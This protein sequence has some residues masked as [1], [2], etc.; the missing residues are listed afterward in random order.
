MARWNAWGNNY[1]GAGWNDWGTG[2]GYWEGSV[3][4]PF[5]YGDVL[6]FALWPYAFYDPFFAYGADFLLTSIFWPG[7]LF[8]PYYAYSPYAYNPY[9][10]GESSLFDIYGN[11][12][13]ANGY[14]DYGGYEGRHHQP[15]H[16]HY[17]RRLYTA[18]SMAN[19]NLAAESS[20]CL[21]CG[22]LAPGVVSLPVEQIKR[23]I[24]PTDAQVAMLNDLKAASAEADNILRASC[25]AEV[26]LTPLARLDAVA[27]R[28]EAMI[29]AVRVLRPPLTTLYNSLDSE[30]KDRLA[31]IGME[32]KY[33]RAK[34]AGGESAATNLG[35]L[36]KQQTENFTQLPVQRIEQLI[37]PTGEQNGAFD[38]LKAASTKAAADLDASCPSEIPETLTD[39]L[40]AAAKRLDAL[41]A[42]VNTVKPALA[43]FYNS[44][45]DEQKAR[46]N[47]IGRAS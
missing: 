35:G 20:S 42:A 40:D 41:A 10:Y 37:K 27:K 17:A 5:F 23:A 29:K 39:R 7:P 16:R 45:T 21:T 22:G 44:L 11:A 46:F 14:A 15:H 38:A 1:W 4:W 13:Y 43:D 2:W 9:Y 31:A 19:A 34:A 26:P 8:S 3:F 25:P 32:A 6:T 33:R 30:Q 28:I 12:P 18:R 36:C 24:R 47:V